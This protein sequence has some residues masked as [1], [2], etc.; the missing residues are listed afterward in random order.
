MLKRIFIGDR[1]D[2]NLAPALGGRLA[3]GQFDK[4]VSFSDKEPVDV[5]NVLKRLSVNGRDEVTLSDVHSRLSQ[6]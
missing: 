6:R 5:V 2:H 1:L 4:F 3:D